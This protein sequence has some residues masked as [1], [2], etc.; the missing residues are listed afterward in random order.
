MIFRI[1]SAYAFSI[2][3]IYFRI[4]YKNP[5]LPSFKNKTKEKQEY[6]AEVRLYGNDPVSWCNFLKIKKGEANLKKIQN[7]NR[8]KI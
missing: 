1:L 4:T 2:N 8:R 5:Q 7:K 6:E 3:C